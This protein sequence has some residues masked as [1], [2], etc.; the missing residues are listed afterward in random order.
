MYSFVL[1]ADP[2]RLQAICDRQLNLGG[3]VVYRPLGPFV[4]FIAATMGPVSSASPAA[5]TDEKDFGFWVPVLAGRRGLG[6]EFRAERPAFFLPYLWVDE[7][8][9]SQT[10]REVFGYP[11]GVGRLRNPAAPGDPAEFSIDALVVPEFGP[12]GAPTSR[13]QWQRLVTASRR[14]GDPWTSLAGEIGSIA[15]LGRAVVTAIA[16]Q[17][18]DHALPEPTLALLRSLARDALALE[19]PMVFLKQFRDAADGRMACYQAIV[20]SANRMTRDPI[21]AGVLPG[22]WEL[23]IA[24]FA[25][26][27]LIDRLG[28]RARPSDGKVPA[29]FHFWAKFAFTAAPGRVVWRA[30]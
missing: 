19:V 10:G 24:Q 20:E 13:W 30:V 29:A 15:S 9:A 3:P 5:W 6:G 28:L 11:K 1:E 16:R 25:D 8:L 14:G 21:A 7:Y 23:S 18:G 26:V 12:P 4:F 22:D 17:L 27:R 2:D